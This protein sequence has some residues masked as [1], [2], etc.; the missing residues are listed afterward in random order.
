M[1][2]PLRLDPPRRR[3]FW[4]REDEDALGAVRLPSVT[5]TRP[6]TP[7]I[8]G[9][10][11]AP[12]RTPERTTLPPVR[13]TVPPA[14]NGNFI[15]NAIARA[16]A[17]E[18]LGVPKADREAETK[19]FEHNPGP[20]E[21]LLDLALGNMAAPLSN[22]AANMATDATLERFLKGGGDLEK[23]ETPFAVAGAVGDVVGN[24]GLSRGIQVPGG[25]E[26]ATLAKRVLSRAATGAAENVAT[27]AAGIAAFGTDADGGG[28]DPMAILKQ[29]AGDAVTGAVFG[30][31][32]EGVVGKFGGAPD[33]S[34]RIELGA[35][36]TTGEASRGG[37][38]AQARAG[39]LDP[40]GE[41]VARLADRRL[42]DR[43]PD[44][45]DLGE[46]TPEL[47][48]AL[49]GPAAPRGPG[50]AG[51]IRL[52]RDPLPAGQEPR[53]TAYTAPIDDGADPRLANLEKLN[54]S[55][56]AETKIRDS[57]TRL[58]LEKR[59]VS[60]DET[61]AAADEL[62]IN[63]ARLLTKEGR[64]RGDE[65]LAVRDVISQN[66][67]RM[68]DLAA[69]KA[70]ATTD[71]ARHAAQHQIN[72]LSEETDQ[73]LKRYS[74]ERTRAGRDL[75][76]LRIVARNTMDP[77]VWLAQAQRVKADLPLDSGEAAEVS[78]LALAND[79]DGLIRYVS[80]LHRSTP[81]EKALTLWKAGLL[82]SP[83]THLKN[84]VGNTL[85]AGAETVKE[86]PAAAID[87]VIS[88]WPGRTRTKAL[89]ARGLITEQIR[90][91]ST[92]LKAA[93]RI[94]RYGADPEELARWDFRR[95]N[96]GPSAAGRIAQAYTDGVFNALGAS[97]AVFKAAAMGRAVEEYARVEARAR[98]KSGAAKTFQEALAALRA[99]FPPE[100]MVKA[101]GDAE[102]ATF[103]Q[104]NAAAAGFRGLKAGL[105][106]SGAVGR[107]AA[108]AADVV[109]PFIKTPTNVAGSLVQY[110]PLGL[111]TALVKQ[112]G[113]PSQKRLSEDLG[114][115]IT[116]SA[117]VALGF[118]L[119][120]EGKAT[121][122]APSNAAERAQWDLENKPANAVRIGNTWRNV[123]TLS[124]VGALVAVGAQMYQASQESDS[125]SG[126][127]VAA[128]L[129]PGRVALDQSFLKGV[130]GALN[131]V[132]DPS[133][134]GESFVENTAGSVV[135]SIVGLVARGTDPYQRD[136]SGPLERIQSRIPGLSQQ[137]PPR[138]NAF[139]QP[140]RQ[141]GGVL[142]QAFDVTQGRTAHETP[143]LAEMRRLGVNVGFPS[144]TRTVNG[145]STRR[146][147]EEYRTLLQQ[148]GPE[149][150]R[151]LTEK[152]TGPAWR[153]LDDETKRERLENIV[154]SVRSKEYKRERLALKRTA[155]R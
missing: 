47:A 82:T 45:L 11:T 81:T 112:I 131:A 48:T 19:A 77:A 1:T 36:R 70:A 146:T 37:M 111:V 125:P 92:G 113:N 87:A 93:R 23:W 72:A 126:K 132:N 4:E 101:I 29:L 5:V 124:P 83:A 25:G 59:K 67:K 114:R 9:P 145:V 26:G 102:I 84:T 100:L 75:N 24:I 90:G 94:L 58:G 155:R 27:G 134:Y 148:L 78:R 120:H 3:R 41:S 40:T 152:L 21:T 31:A 95:T 151:R 56:A 154:S 28:H 108:T 49:D 138:L 139:G 96:F 30:G 99:D 17:Q 16:Q 150:E 85:M 8:D 123:S 133:R 128:A 55:P 71:E 53:G 33:P 51:I 18:K 54:L 34:P 38:F 103:Q 153:L 129:T 107:G 142:A 135:P 122:A 79:R 64:L 32:V 10:F 121:G 12:S 20:L 89:S 52:G 106:R 46:A 98:V 127:A 115:S 68:V 73:F 141:N 143:L 110:S 86:V 130:S 15:A 66:A 6:P 118:M 50:R 117:L 62:G 144:R 60:W 80:G 65:V 44:D 147:P 88:I 76:A 105:R 61:K 14:D 91:A 116:G 22:R 104:E 149:T 69:E 119:A 35:S 2:L 13:V 63:P 140:M 109:V 57:Y 137:V 39:R 136:P 97:D 43:A 7:A 74:T 42:L